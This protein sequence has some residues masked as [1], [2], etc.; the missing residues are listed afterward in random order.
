M[1]E[2]TEKLKIWIKIKITG[3]IKQYNKEINYK[4]Y[5]KMFLENRFIDNFQPYKNLCKNDNY[6]FIPE[7]YEF[8]NILKE[9]L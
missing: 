6:T 4:N 5:E 3:L 2:L 1:K 9:C 8:A 7:N